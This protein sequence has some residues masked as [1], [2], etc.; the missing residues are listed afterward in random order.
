MHKI[1]VIHVLWSVTR[2]EDRNWQKFIVIMQ[3][4]QANISIKVQN[5]NV[6]QISFKMSSYGS[7]KTNL[8]PYF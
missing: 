5:S 3:R 4:Y 8:K 1:Q 2:Q 7:L 6:S